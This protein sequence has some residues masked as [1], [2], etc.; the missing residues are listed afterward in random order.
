MIPNEGEWTYAF[1]TEHGN[2]SCGTTQ[3][4]EVRRPLAAVSK[5]TKA[6]N[7]AF[8]DEDNDWI[9]DKRDPIIKE[10]LK[11]V[12][13]VRMKT[14]MHEHKG[15]YRLRAWLLP[16]GSQKIKTDDAGKGAPR[17]FARQGA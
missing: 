11:L 4:G 3:V 9:L 7:I 6:K 15:T 5:I 8:F 1:M 17:P 2:I 13:K 14:R 16:E 12:A 10:I